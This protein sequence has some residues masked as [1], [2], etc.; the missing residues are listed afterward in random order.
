LRFEAGMPL[1]GHEISVDINPIE[2]GFKWACDFEKDFIGKNALR[3]ILERG[4]T[5]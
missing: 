2:A 3:A 4:V 1:H 5:R